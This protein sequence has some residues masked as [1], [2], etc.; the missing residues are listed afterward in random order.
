M[1]DAKGDLE[2]SD[3]NEPQS[4]M[5]RLGPQYRGDD[6]FTARMRAHQS[7]WR[8]TRLRVPCGTGPNSTSTTRYGSFLTPDDARRGLN[9]LHPRIFDAV[10]ARIAAGP[11]VEEFRCLHNLLSSQPL[12]F[13][14]FGLLVDDPE[15]AT[16]FLSALLPD[17][18]ARVRSVCVEYSRGPK[19]EYLDDATAFDAFVIYDRFDGAPAFLGIETKLSEPFSPHRYDSPRYREIA[20]ASRVF[21]DPDSL[22]LGD[23]RWNQL[24]RDH[25]LVQA[26]VQHP[27][28]PEVLT[29][30][31]VVVHHP[32][33]S[34]C[35]A[36]LAGYRGL[37]APG[38]AIENWPLDWL[39]E[40]WA[41]HAR[42]EEHHRWVDA[43]RDRYVDLSLSDEAWIALK[44]SPDGV[45]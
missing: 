31:L 42:V 20:R 5:E 38:A 13:N 16:R 2:S 23:V 10:R 45:T 44:A 33:D 36:A 32:A 19:W 17:E 37:L 22:E 43:L 11:G 24:W 8:A 15:T 12:C 29:G 6:S 21:R 28:A 7:W 26:H 39:V 35:L 3:S 41:D 14:L 1:A 9:F 34:R 25:L 18:I 40:R 30:R 27:S 4:L